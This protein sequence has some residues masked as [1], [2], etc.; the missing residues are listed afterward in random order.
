MPPWWA[1]PEGKWQVGRDR[2]RWRGGWG[3]HVLKIGEVLWT[4]L[5]ESRMGKA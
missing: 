1:R 5:G 2:E 4:G 3:D